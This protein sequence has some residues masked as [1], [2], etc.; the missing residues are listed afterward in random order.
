MAKT[1]TFAFA[2]TGVNKLA[3]AEIREQFNNLQ[4]TFEDMKIENKTP[5]ENLVSQECSSRRG[6]L[7]FH[8]YVKTND[9]LPND[10]GQLVRGTL[11]KM[12]I[13][14]WKNVRISR[15]HRKG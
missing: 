1:A 10:C 11:R 14:N 8:G 3:I 6:N 12:G 13:E 7:L 5:R 2:S 4:H 9:E 15:C